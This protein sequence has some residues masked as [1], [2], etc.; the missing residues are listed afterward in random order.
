M[1]REFSPIPQR[2]LN[3]ARERQL[4]LRRDPAPRNKTGLRHT[5]TFDPVVYQHITRNPNFRDPDYQS[6]I[7]RQ[8]PETV[9]PHDPTGFIG[10][11]GAGGIPR[12]RFGR[13]KERYIHGI[14]WISFDD[15]ATMTRDIG[16]TGV[17]D[18]TH[19]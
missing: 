13:V 7:A 18:H 1:E 2:M 3:A 9:I 10:G 16:D 14:G 5:A 6:H 19:V 11:E 12:T 4:R 15:S 8:H 17:E